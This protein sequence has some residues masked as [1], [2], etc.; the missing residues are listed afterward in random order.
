MIAYNLR[1]KSYVL[2]AASHRSPFSPAL[3]E[4]YDPFRHRRTS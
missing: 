2:S 4:A 3:G 1:P